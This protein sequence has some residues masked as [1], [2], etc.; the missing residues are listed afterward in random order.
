MEETRRPVRIKPLKELKPGRMAC[1][2]NVVKFV[3]VLTDKAA[4]LAT[5]WS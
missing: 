4:N 5:S 2:H 3:M 1:E